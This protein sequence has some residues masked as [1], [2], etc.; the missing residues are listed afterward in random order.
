M[1]ETGEERYIYRERYTQWEREKGV[2]G[3]RERKERVR[4][5]DRKSGLEWEN[6]K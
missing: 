6:G 5:W 3:K 2:E 1:R 4:E